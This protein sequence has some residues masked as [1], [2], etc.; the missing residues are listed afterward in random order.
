MK[1][2][3]VNPNTSGFVTERMVAAAQ[4]VLGDSAQVSGLTAARGPA[5]VGTR[6]ENAL[7][8]ANALELAAACGADTDAVLL[9]ISTDAGL[10]PV[11][12]LLKVPAAGMLEAALLTACQLGGRIGL[13]TVG[14]RML[15]VYQERAV[16]YRLQ[17]R[18]HGWRCIDLPAAYAPE[19]T[20]AVADALAVAAT[21]LVQAHD[22]DAIVLAGAVLAGCR[23]QVQPR[24]PVPVI[25]ALEAAA[26]QAFALA[27]L[28]PAKARSGSYAAPSG[29]AVTGVGA[30]LQAQLGSTPR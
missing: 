3:L 30:E 2:V 18:M 20:E 24:V 17:D 19:R 1:I 10:E 6:S 26:L 14:A 5:I 8:A 12:E 11:R 7:A 9:G 23:A 13:L 22:L 25:D 29:R 4:A 21:E 15:P 27:R 28:R 16:A